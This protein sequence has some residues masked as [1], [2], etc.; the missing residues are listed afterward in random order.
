MNHLPC[1]LTA[2]QWSDQW[3][4]V[5]SF[6][7]PVSYAYIFQQFLQMP[8]E[9]I[10]WWHVLLLRLC[11]QHKF[12]ELGLLGWGKHFIVVI[13][14]W[15]IIWL[16]KKGACPQA[17]WLNSSLRTYSRWIES[18]TEIVI[19]L[20]HVCISPSSAYRSL[21]PHSPLSKLYCQALKFCQSEEWEITSQW[22]VASVCLTV[23]EAVCPF[24]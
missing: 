13:V 15:P 18:S 19:W 3:T 4:H 9:W 22:V 16:R 20:P 11:L 17:W 6:I 23:S 2:R 10:E 24:I 8:L 7:Q 21:F 12:L 14:I 5:L 1:L